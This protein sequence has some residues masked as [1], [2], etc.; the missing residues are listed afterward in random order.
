MIN[1]FPI[2]KAQTIDATAQPTFGTI[3]T[4][5][6]ST[7]TSSM[8]MRSDKTSVN[9]GDKFKVTVEIKTNTV[10]INEYRIIIDFDATKLQVVDQDPTTAGTQV[11]LLDTIFTVENAEIDNTV[12]Q[13]GRITLIAKTDS[14][15]PFAVNRD[16]AEIQFQAQ[17]AGSPTIK[18]IQD[19]SGSRLIRQS[20]VGVSFTPNQLSVTVQA[21]TGSATTTTTG[22]TPPPISQTTTTGGTTV[23]TTI[24]VTGVTD[25]IGSAATIIVAA[26]LILTGLKL[27]G[28]KKR[29][30]EI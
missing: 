3:D 9:V 6:G 18:I 1:L 14:G 4:G 13:N 5:G 20:G 10:T 2:V 26:V 8:L 29:N 11:K 17:A 27:S 7:L 30:H 25:D 28:D 21:A 24:P 16:V 19:A 15:N 12:S 22:A 23:G